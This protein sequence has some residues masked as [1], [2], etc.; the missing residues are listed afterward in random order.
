MPSL[1]QFQDNSIDEKDRHGIKSFVMD[2]N[3]GLQ[4]PSQL[5]T[6][7]GGFFEKFDHERKKV[8]TGVTEQLDIPN[9]CGK[10]PKWAAYDRKV[11]RFWAYRT[12]GEKKQRYIMYYYLQDDTIHIDEIQTTVSTIPVGLSGIF[13]RRHKIPYIEEDRFYNWKDI[14]INKTVNMY[15]SVFK[16]IKCDE[17]T[18]TFYGEKGIKQGANSDFPA[19]QT[20]RLI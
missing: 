12:D 11:L 10:E 15:S 5:G 13:L 17:R 3:A 19:V 7:P 18:R 2:P 1:P 4:K 14:S 6:L 9:D 8:G 16:I 20:T